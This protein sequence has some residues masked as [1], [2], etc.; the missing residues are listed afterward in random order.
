MAVEHTV[1][2][3]T[4]ARADYLTKYPQRQTLAKHRVWLPISIFATVLCL[5]YIL[6]IGQCSHENEHKTKGIAHQSQ[7][8]K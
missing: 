2:Q 4:V 3:T 7:Y 5:R 1:V 8:G 6:R